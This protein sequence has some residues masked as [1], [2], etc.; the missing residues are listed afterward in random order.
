M[1]EAIVI[2]RTP[3]IIA[4]EIRTLSNQFKQL[5]LSY[6]IQIGQKLCEAK[7]LVDH[8]EWTDW[9]QKNTEFGRSTAENLMRIFEEYGADQVGIFGDAK[10]Q[11]LGNLSYTKAL[12]LLDVPAEEREEFAQ[13]IDA[14]HLSTR[15]LEQAIKERDEAVKQKDIVSGKLEKSDKDLAKLKKSLQDEEGKAKKYNDEA[16]RLKKQL[17]ELQKRPIEVNAVQEDGEGVIS[18]QL[19]EAEAERDRAQ[20]RAREL[21]RKLATADPTTAQFKALY[22]ETQGILSKLVGLIGTAPD[23]KR[24]GL[25]RSLRAL[26]ETYSGLVR[27]GAA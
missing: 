16:L 8:G 27:E 25:R 1:S 6:A 9:V 13:T 21:E 24:D 2:T 19:R 14:E 12:K 17:E 22:E 4:V 23:E 18:E 15:E 26:F 5:A 3:E 7:A 20:E 11:T 10:S